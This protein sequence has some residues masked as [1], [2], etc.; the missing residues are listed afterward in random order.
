[1]S[2][3]SII[4]PVYNVEKYLNACV[5]SIVKQTYADLEIIL[6]DDGSTDNSGRLC[7]QWMEEDDR[8]VVIHKKNGGL[9]DARNVGLD[10][11]AGDWI[12]FVDSDDFV[13][14]DMVKISLEIAEKNNSDLVA[15]DC[16]KVNDEC[17][18]VQADIYELGEE[19]YTGKGLLRE[20]VINEKGSMVAW[21]K[22]YRKEL[23]ETLRY[24]V[25]KI[26]EDEFVITDILEA[27]K[28]ATVINE[29]LYYY[30]QREGSIID[31]KNRKAEYDALEAFDL[32]CRKLHGNKE[33][34]Q[35]TLNRYLC[36]LIKIYFLESKSERKI[37]LNRFREKLKISL[38]YTCWKTN[39]LF[40]LFSVTPMVYS[41]ITRLA[42]KEK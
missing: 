36:Q 39:I 41:R 12:M 15:F 22:L 10:S 32:R 42:F 30:R 17:D 34:Y 24:P 33:L 4:V 18:S 2:T 31:T 8:I 37:L 19:N 29:K 26:H 27:V 11:A 28:R 38:K 16:L 5:E 1:M 23:W 6:V 7:D 21:N 3:V 35:L 40:I 14:Q 9:S 20:F 13:H 25:G